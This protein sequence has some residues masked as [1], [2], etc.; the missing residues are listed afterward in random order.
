MHS[1]IFA[2]RDNLKIFGFHYVLWAEGLSLR[3][4]YTIWCAY[5]MIR[6][7]RASLTLKG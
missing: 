1:H 3:T 5:G 4:L 2:I 6:H 7:D